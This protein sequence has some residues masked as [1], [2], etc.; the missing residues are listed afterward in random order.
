VVLLIVATV[1][2]GCST[3]GTGAGGDTQEGSADV[4]AGRDLYAQNCAVCHGPQA[5]G[6]AQ[7]PT[8]LHEVYVPSHHA[9]E[10]FQA[11]V[12]RG[13]QPHHWDFGPMQPIPGLA[14]DEVTD[15]TAHV[16]SLQAEAGV[17]D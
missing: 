14:R 6:T 11:A 17:I 13:V 16:R 2:Y 1:L 10:A 12:A 3:G 9:D 7:G 8:F 5:E 4:A 15:I